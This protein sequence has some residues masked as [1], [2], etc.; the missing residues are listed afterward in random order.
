MASDK[1]FL[2]F[3]LERCDGLSARPMMGEYL[4]YLD[5][6]YVTGICDNRLLVKPTATANTMMPNAEYQAPYEGAKEMIL[7][8][9]LD[10]KDFLKRLFESVSRELPSPKKKK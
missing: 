2:E 6:K 7:V 10:D 4:L 8:D 9:N 5:G 3:V 1:E